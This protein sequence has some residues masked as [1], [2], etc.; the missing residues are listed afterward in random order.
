VG[1]YLRDNPACVRIMN[2]VQN[3]F[4]IFYD[5]LNLFLLSVIHLKVFLPIPDIFQMQN[6][7][8]FFNSV[9]HTGII[10]VHHTRHSANDFCFLHE[11]RSGKFFAPTK[12]PLNVPDDNVSIREGE[13]FIFLCYKS[14]TTCARMREKRGSVSARLPSYPLIIVTDN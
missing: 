8:S 7:N 5:D 1:Y 9:I 14:T 4:S 11:E 6:Q 13:K 10:S 12:K 2:T 3:N